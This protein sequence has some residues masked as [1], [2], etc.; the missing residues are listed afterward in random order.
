MA[1]DRLAV[2]DG[3]D[4]L[5][6]T[7]PL[8]DIAKQRF[9]DFVADLTTSATE[10]VSRLDDIDHANVADLGF[11]PERFP[12]SMVDTYR[13]LCREAGKLPDSSV[14]A[15]LL[16]AGRAV[17][18]APIVP[19]TD[20]TAALDLLGPRFELILATKGDAQVQAQRLKQSQLSGFFA[21][22]YIFMDKTEQEFQSI[23]AAHG[24]EPKAAW[25]VGNSVR[26]DINPALR[27]GFSAVLIPRRTWR[28]EDEPPLSSRRLFI[29]ASL[30]EAAEV[31]IAA[32]EHP[33]KK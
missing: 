29:R 24:C 10:A 17:F 31:M 2:F 18:S 9:A 19:F 4:T 13:V 1:K 11:S 20:A 7:M 3:D 32:V 33:N 23:L 21:K 5:W 28:Y 14:E 12:R 8:Y 30:L 6:S 15:Q 25:S 27:A 16:H 22:T 26:S